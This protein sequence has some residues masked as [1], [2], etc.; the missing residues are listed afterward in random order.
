MTRVPFK[1]AKISDNIWWVGAVDWNLRN[2]HGYVTPRGSTYN[3]YLV[4]DEKIALID[5]VKAPF[6]QELI[7]RISTVIPTKKIDYVIANHV[8]MD[9]SGS[10]KAIREAAPNAQFVSDKKAAEDIKRHFKSDWDFKLV[11]TGDS[12]SLGKRSLTFVEVPMVHWPDSMVTYCPDDKILFPNDAFGQHVASS[13]RF[14]DEF[15]WEEVRDEAAK[16]YANIVMPF[17]GPVKKALN[18]VSK[19]DI[20]MIAPSHGLIWRSNIEKIISSYSDWANN[21]TIKKC[22]VVYDTMWNSTEMMARSLEQGLADSGIQTRFCNLRTT[23][24]TDIM[25]EILDARAVAVGT[26]TLNNGMMPT[27]SAFLTY[28]KGLKPKGRLGFVF[29]SHGWAGGGSKTVEE[30][31]RSA[32]FEIAMPTIECKYV[33][34]ESELHAICEAGMNLGKGIASRE[35]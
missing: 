24:I 5:T 7:E 10:L 20:E 13:E 26:P 3:A 2:F 18:A 27:V 19:L 6:A 25:K 11:K 15:P 30:V 14:D 35:E 31:L 4:I 17:D 8:E 32:G 33:P 1:A 9:H 12:I 21:R 28:M 34:D 22:V 29:G 16:Y 23:E